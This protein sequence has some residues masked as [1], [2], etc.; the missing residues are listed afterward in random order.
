MNALQNGYVYDSG[1]SK[2]HN[3][4]IL[5]DSCIPRFKL[6]Y[7]P[8]EIDKGLCHLS[9]NRIFGQNSIFVCIYSAY[10]L[11]WSQFQGNQK[12]SNLSGKKCQYVKAD[13]LM[14]RSV[15]IDHHLSRAHAHMRERVI[16][17]SILYDFVFCVSDWLA[18]QGKP[19]K[20]HVI[21][22]EYA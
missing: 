6:V 14:T 8:R 18:F 17:L 10:I 15:K 1:S 21:W 5:Y 20:R 2:A 13:S 9:R 22:T 3:L 11:N 4:L 12:N 19:T 16:K 7:V